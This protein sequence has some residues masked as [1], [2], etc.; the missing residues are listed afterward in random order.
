MR[1]AAGG[2]GRRGVGPRS[3]GADG[4]AHQ[5]PPCTGRRREGPTPK[6]RVGGSGPQGALPELSPPAR[7]SP[8]ALAAQR[9]RHCRPPLPAEAGPPPTAGL[10]PESPGA[11]ASTQHAR[12]WHHRSV[13]QSPLCHT[14][15]A[16]PPGGLL[17]AEQELGQETKAEPPH[18]LLAS[19]PERL[20][21]PGTPEALSCPPRP[22]ASPT[23]LL[24][25]QTAAQAKGV[26]ADCGGKTRALPRE[27]SRS[28]GQGR[29]WGAPSAHD[30]QIRVV[31]VHLQT[32][33]KHD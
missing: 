2:A 23:R 13:H 12:A 14:T 25:W 28:S 4:G 10:H 32:P 26:Q 30:P 11:H 31:E 8:Q 19:A 7:A 20:Q 16:P 6:P 22:P 5:R 17:G 1:S 18:P 24:S 9:P 33:R 27:R 21:A 29:P 15:C 3:R